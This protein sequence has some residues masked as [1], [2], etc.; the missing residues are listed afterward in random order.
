MTTKH[1]DGFA[2]WPTNTNSHWNA[3]RVGPKKDIIGELYEAFKLKHG[4]HFGL[5]YSLFEWDHP[6]YKFDKENN[7]TTRAYVNHVMLPQ[8][9]EIVQRYKP[10][11]IWA[12]GDWDTGY[13]YWRSEDFLAWLYTQSP[14][15]DDVVVNDRWGIGTACKHGD[16]KTCGIDRFNPHM[17]EPFKWENAMTIDRHSWG[18]R[19]NADISD[20]YS[21]HQL[22]ELLVE[23]VSNGGNILMNIGPDADGSIPEVFIQRLTEIG[24]WLRVNGEA[25]YSTKP[26]KVQKDLINP[27]IRYTQKVGVVYAILMKWP[28]KLIIELHSPIVTANTKI[29]LLGYDREIVWQPIPN[30]PYGLQILLINNYMNHPKDF[31]WVFKMFYVE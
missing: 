31:T 9:K 12:D 24:K 5:Y 8:L 4:L 17:V 26:W 6:L 27:N 18:Y 3:Y 23:T 28:N 16:V 2:L 1:H 7:F 30:Q 19:K 10:E 13:E 14:V 20:Y 22:V 29:F 11:Y 21:T 15:R 25:I